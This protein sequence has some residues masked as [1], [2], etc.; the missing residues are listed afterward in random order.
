MLEQ[1]DRIR[2]RVSSMSSTVPR[3][4][5]IL[6]PFLIGLEIV[7]TSDDDE[8]HMFSTPKCFKSREDIFTSMERK[9][10]KEIAI[11]LLSFDNSRTIAS[12]WWEIWRTIFFERNGWYD[13]T[14]LNAHLWIDLT[15]RIDTIESLFLLSFS[16][17]NMI[18][19]ISE[20][21][22]AIVRP[23]VSWGG[24]EILWTVKWKKYRGERR[25]HEKAP[26]IL[27]ISVFCNAQFDQSRRVT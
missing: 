15:K 19:I 24:I 26:I 14:C 22:L 11:R 17:R 18:R 9:D 7:E 10:R 5:A 13:G 20:G 1:R 8:S 2:R 23:S 3:H 4:E 12:H 16:D 21:I 27:L 25:V 6:K